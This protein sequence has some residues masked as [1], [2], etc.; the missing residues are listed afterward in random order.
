MP[1]RDQAVLAVLSLVLLAMGLSL[2]LPSAIAPASAP[3]AQPVPTSQA[4]P[5]VEGVVGPLDQVSPLSMRTQAERNAVALVFSGLVRLGPEQSIVGDLADVWDADPTGARWTFH[6]R[7][8]AVWQDGAPVTADDVDFTVRTLRAP[9]YAGPG[10]ASWKEVTVTVVDRKVVRFDLATPLGGFL[11][12]ATQPLVPAHLLDGVSPAAL[13]SP[14]SPFGRQPVGAGPY[15]VA[16]LSNGRL[17]LV[18]TTR[19]GPKIGRAHV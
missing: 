14:T 19:S 18:P 15:R 1:R 4:R 10:G 9:D 17:R 16:S 5:Y 11:Q 3:T 8:D 12:A 2:G 6:I 13:S 7:D